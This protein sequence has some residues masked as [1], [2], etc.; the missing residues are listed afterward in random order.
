M[1]DAYRW[2]AIYADGSSLSEYDA[3]GTRH[4]FKE[5]DQGRLASFMI[6]PVDRPDL[7]SHAIHASPHYRV[8]FRRRHAIS[9][10]GDEVAPS[11][12]I[13]GAEGDGWALYTFHFDSGE[14]FVSP[15][16]DAADPL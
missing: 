15:D 3:D 10:G 7:R 14:S 8:E 4:G 9:T 1:N 2:H 16:I 5:V 13:L 6:A 12:T 11:I